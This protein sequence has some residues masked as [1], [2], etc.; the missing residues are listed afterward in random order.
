MLYKKTITVA[1]D[2]AAWLEAM[3]SDCGVENG[4]RDPRCNDCARMDFQTWSKTAVF[5]DGVEMDI[6]LCPGCTPW[7][8]A[9]LFLNGSE[10]CCTEP[11]DS[12]LSDWV[13]ELNGNQYMVEVVKE[14]DSNG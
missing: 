2:D 4:L 6:K 10:C 5:P 9:V 1:D 14:G 11:A 8:E 12:I 3:L 13:L 7:T